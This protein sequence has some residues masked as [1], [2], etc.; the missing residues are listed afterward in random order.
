[1]FLVFLDFFLLSIA[2]HV[3]QNDSVRGRL[4]ATF[5]RENFF[6]KITFAS[7]GM[8]LRR[9]IIKKSYFDKLFRQMIQIFFGR[10]YFLQV[11]L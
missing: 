2:H 7:I 11:F 6:D 5:V 4:L 8:C 10:I 3:C 9:Q 1:M